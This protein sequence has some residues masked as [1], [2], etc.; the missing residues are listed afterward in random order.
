VTRSEN[1]AAVHSKNTHPELA[2]R[3][4]VH[5]MGYRFTLHKAGLPGTPDL[6]FPSRRKVIFVH[7]CF[8]HQHGCKRSSAPRSNVAFWRRKLGRNRQRDAAN[9]RALRGRG[10]DCLVIWQCDLANEAQLKRR[11]RRFMERTSS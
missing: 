10:W 1:M 7:G 11:I 6:V 3:R 5:A 2:V 8:W 4:I 9:L